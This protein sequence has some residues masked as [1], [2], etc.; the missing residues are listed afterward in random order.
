MRIA[1]AAVTLLVGFGLSRVIG[2]LRDVV[3]AAQFGATADYD[4]YVA[5]FR[6]P[7]VVFMLVAG[8]ALGSTLVPVLAERR[9]QGGPGAD[10]RLASTVF[11]AVFL[12]ALGGALLGILLAPWLAPFVGAGFAPEDQDRLALLV[13][14]I[15]LQPVLLGASEVLTRYLNV[16][17]H[18]ATPALA[19]ALYNVPIMV[20]AIA[21]GPTLG[22]VGLAAGV[23]AGAALYLLVQLPAA[24]NRGFRFAPALH[25][26]DPA[27]G[28]IGRLMV[29]RMLGQGAVQL[30]FIATTRLASQLPEGSLVVLTLGWQLMNLPLGP[31]GMALGNAA[32]PTLAAHAARGDVDALG[33]TAR[34]TLGAILLLILPAALVLIVAGLPLVRLLYERGSFTADDS[35]RTALALAIYGAGLPAHGALEII[36]RTFYALQ[37]TR[38]P[39]AIGVGAMALNVGIAYAL[40]ERFG[41][42]AIPIGTSVSTTLE[43]VILWLLL[44][45]QVPGLASPAVFL[46]DPRAGWDVIAARVR[47]FRRGGSGDN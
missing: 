47:R 6:I 45:P 3:L 16:R 41:F 14:I 30:S 27:L 40:V 7:D 19:P 31:L 5:A 1:G 33:G 20:A 35:T 11:N 13:R 36:T 18:F 4:V 38:T 26:K 42:A 9:E 32:L 28:Q 39:V 25:L 10:A 23:V 29:P 22:N 24:L 2:A 21:L 15:L 12:T 37:D 8:G 44:R 46:P 17:G 34:R 43:V